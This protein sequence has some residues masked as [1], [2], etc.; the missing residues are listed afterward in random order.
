MELVTM[1]SSRIFQMYLLRNSG[2][3]LSG[4]VLATPAFA[5]SYT[6]FDIGTLGGKA[7]YATAINATSQVTRNSVTVDG[8]Y[9]AFVTKANGVDM[10]DLRTFTGGNNS[11]GFG[12]F[13]GSCNALCIYYRC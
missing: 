6:A 2:I 7:T 13:A 3:I 4:L 9:H 12:R 1:K 8:P 10:S 5:Q 11:Y